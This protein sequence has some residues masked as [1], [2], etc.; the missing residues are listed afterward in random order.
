M[1]LTLSGIGIADLTDTGGHNSFT[2]SG[3]TGGGTLTGLPTDTI[4][5]SKTGGF[6][7]TNTSLTDTGDAMSLTLSGI[8]LV[9]LTDTGNGHT[10]T[11]GGWTG[12]GSLTDSGGTSDTV[13]AFKNAS[14]TLTNTLLTS[15]DGMSLTLS[16]IKT[17][18]LKDTG[19]NHSFTVSGWTGTG[20]LIGTSTDA[21]AASKAGGFD[22]DSTSLESPGDL[23]LLTLSGIGI[24]NLTDMSSGGPYGFDVQNWTGSGTLTNA[25]TSRDIITVTAAAGFTLT[26]T[27]VT[28]TA[29]MS[30]ILAGAKG[31]SDAEL[32]DTGGGNNF[33]VS[34]WTAGG[35]LS[36]SAAS[37]TPGT[38]DTLTAVKSA[39]YTLTQTGLS[40]SDGMNIGLM[41]FTDLYLTD[42]GGNNSFNVTGFNG[43]ATLTGPP[44]DSIVASNANFFTSF[45]LTNTSLTE[46]SRL[47]NITLAGI[48]IADLTDAQGGYSFNV[49]GW[50]GGGSLSNLGSAGADTVIASKGASF[51]L[52]NTSLSSTDGMSMALSDIVTAQLTDTSGGNGFTIGGWTG[53]GSLTNTGTATDTVIASKSAN[54]TLTNT[55]LS[56]SDGMSMALSDIG[57]ANLTDTGGNHSFTASGW[58][59]GGILTGLSTDTVIASKNGSFTLAKSSLTDTADSMDLTLSGIGKAQLTDTGAGHSF[60]V[61]GWTGDGSLTDS[62]GT[63]DTVIASKNASFTLTNTSLSSSDGM[64]MT[65]SGIIVADLSDTGN[66]NSFTVSNWTHG[67]ALTG[68]VTDAVIA[69]KNGGFTL[70]NASLSDTGDTMSMTLSGI[71]T[72]NLT[73]TGTSHSF[74]V[75]GWTHFGTLTGT[76]TDTVVASKNGNFR[77]F[78]ENNG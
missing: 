2:V 74:T 65:L 41:D 43:A 77:F 12:G 18:D 47:M 59:G 35:N 36:D 73:D 46:A 76:S 64:D 40:S 39:S 9:N 27:L 21:V 6:T 71:G 72:A 54:F 10:F 3:W 8:G 24:A 69:V 49:S 28:D 63:S 55:S 16:G 56:S 19:G 26:N 66:D 58:T 5:A 51:M 15:S 38:T 17:A 4:I 78:G 32:T 34:G 11:V 70:T 23:M 50:T 31:F 42:T 7:L 60:T 67:G 13:V 37:P 1:S 61:G 52:S 45:T 57:T 75:T 48:K 29:G 62:G 14:F 20:E 44:T 33:N 30:L 25:T 53:S 68:A 22:L